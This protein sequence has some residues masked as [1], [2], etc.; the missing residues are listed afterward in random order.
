MILYSMNATI[1]GG[2]FI[3]ISLLAETITNT[4]ETG[5]EISSLDV[6][7]TGV[8][9]VF[10]SLIALIVAIKIFT[11]IVKFFED[12]KV[13]KSSSVVKVETIQNENNISDINIPEENNTQLV[14]VITAAIQSCLGIEPRSTLRIKN[15]KRVESY[16]PA[17][18]QASKTELINNK[19]N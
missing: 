2:I 1:G 5:N 13:K 18:S 16:S 3:M 17:W 12:R 19:L 9:V 6:L 7:L 15:I 14:A 4:A 8:T 10:A 11:T